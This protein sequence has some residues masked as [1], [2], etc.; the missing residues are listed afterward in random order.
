[1]AIEVALP[2]FSAVQALKASGF[3]LASQ[4][5]GTDRRD[6]GRLPAAARATKMVSGPPTSAVSCVTAAGVRGAIDRFEIDSYP[7]TSG[8]TG[9]PAAL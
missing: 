2:A 7:K 6:S 3:R 5:V 4:A 8:A 9:M 1:M